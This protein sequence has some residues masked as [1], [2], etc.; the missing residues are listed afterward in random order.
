[1]AD[2]LDQDADMELQIPLKSLY[3]EFVCAILRNLGECTF[4]VREEG[5]REGKEDTG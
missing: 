4:S 2:A 5:E 3:E 1:M